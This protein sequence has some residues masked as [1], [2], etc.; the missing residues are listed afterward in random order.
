M[1]NNAQ[2]DFK[3]IYSNTNDCID[4]NKK[5]KTPNINFDALFDDNCQE[6]YIDFKS[7]EINKTLKITLVDI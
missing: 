7:C 6:F 4:I 1:N 3:Y 5:E 2:N